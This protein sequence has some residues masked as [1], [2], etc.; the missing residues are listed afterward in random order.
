MAT[1]GQAN[2]IDLL[3]NYPG[4]WSTDAASTEHSTRGGLKGEDAME[5][6]RAQAENFGAAFAYNS[7]T[8]LQKADDGIFSVILDGG[9]SSLTAK[10]VIIASGA[11]RRTLNIPGEVEFTGKGVS[12]CATCDGPFFTGKR[13]LV[14]GGGDAAC[15]E[16]MYLSR[17]TPTV[18][19]VHRRGEFRAQKA[20]AER[21][22]KNEHIKVEL[23]TKPVEIKGGAKVGS[24]L[25]EDTQTGAQREEEAEAVFIFAGSTPNLSFLN[26]AASVKPRLDPQGYVITGANMM[27][28]IPGLFAAGDVRDS[29][30]RQVVTSC[31]D[32]AVAAHEAAAYIDAL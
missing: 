16:A 31:A 3:E 27:T 8:G 28:N 6:M 24:V 13:M 12:Y 7:V 11:K 2:N 26:D 18:T 15:D 17:L 5:N 10:T 1:G 30:F 32:G 25:L 20:L 23:W 29:L 4:L 19:L 14:V 9:K 22:L 21:V